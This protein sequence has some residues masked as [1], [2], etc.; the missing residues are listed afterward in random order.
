M[1]PEKE[2]TSEATGKADSQGTT[3]DAEGCEQPEAES[4]KGGTVNRHK[5]ERE[6]G[7]LQEQ[8]KQLEA[9]NGKLK[10]DS[11]SIAALNKR[12]DEMESKA[13]AEKLEASLKAAGCHNVK[14]AI[15]CLDD[16]DGDIGKLKEAAPHR[17]P[18]SYNSKRTRG[19]PKV[20]PGSGDEDEELDKAYGIK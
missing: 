11:E 14:A 8:I 16:Y 7:K 20:K 4:P 15:A 13:K 17:F 10:G 6:I 1:D 5:H 12:L 19:N 3:N 9:E 2:E 18:S